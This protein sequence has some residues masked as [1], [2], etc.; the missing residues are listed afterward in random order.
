MFFESL[1][2]TKELK[3][4]CHLARCGSSWQSGWLEAGG[5]GTQNGPTKWTC[6]QANAKSWQVSARRICT[7]SAC[8]VG[9]LN[10]QIAGKTD[11]FHFHAAQL[12]GSCRNR[13]PLKRGRL[14][15]THRPGVLCQN[16]QATSAISLFTQ[17]GLSRPP[18]L[19]PH[20]CRPDSRRCIQGPDFGIPLGCIRIT[21]WISAT[22]R[23]SSGSA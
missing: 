11:F 13:I 12:Q 17:G 1:I 3:L 8:S 14:V 7:T 19:T 22:A 23:A 21:T 18:Q 2:I 9:F 20:T 16:P 4:F 5:H 6:T 10:L 15:K